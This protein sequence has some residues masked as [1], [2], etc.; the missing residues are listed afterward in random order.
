MKQVDL[1]VFLSAGQFLSVW[2][3]VSNWERR[4][5]VV[6]K[7]IFNV[8]ETIYKEEHINVDQ[9]ASDF[10]CLVIFYD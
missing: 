3:P 8:H 5:F 1:S 7:N 10:V 2:A 4:M 9:C 6:Q